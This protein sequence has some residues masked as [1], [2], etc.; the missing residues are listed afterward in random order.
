[1][2]RA[3]FAGV[4]ALAL[5]P[6]GVSGQTIEGKAAFEKLKGLAG[7]WSGP[8][9]TV[10]GPKG[11]VRYEVV[12]GGSAVMEVLFPGDP[13][14]MRSMYHLDRGDLVMTHYCSA[15]N[16]PRMRLSKTGSTA[17][18]LCSTSTAARTSTWRRTC[19]FTRGRSAFATTARSRRA[20]LRGPEAKPRA[21]TTFS[22]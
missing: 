4:I 20:G 11:T 22:P 15:G 8:V 18:K 5:L 2:K 16:Q 17:A 13:H 9:G 21:R 12:S 10:D 7:T 3:F 1:M 19:T 6:R 14:E